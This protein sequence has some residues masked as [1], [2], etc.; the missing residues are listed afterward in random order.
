MYKGQK[1]SGYYSYRKSE[2]VDRD[3]CALSGSNP[4]VTSENAIFFT[5]PITFEDWNCKQGNIKNTLE[6]IDHDHSF[7]HDCDLQSKKEVMR[8]FRNQG[9]TVFNLKK[10]MTFV[11][12]GM[13]VRMKL[14]MIVSISLRFCNQTVEHVIGIVNSQIVDG[15]Y[16]NLCT[17]PF[18]RSNMDWCAGSE[19]TVASESYAIYPNKKISKAVA[20]RLSTPVK[21]SSKIVCL[22][23]LKGL[24][25]F[26]REKNIIENSC[27]QYSQKIKSLLV[28]IKQPKGLIK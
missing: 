26:L 3:G 15:A 7:L 10:N 12:L 16:K 25:D 24:P 6:C 28:E 21:A 27:E 14:P 19:F 4:P 1:S 2:S 23:D 22:Y 18:T 20:E 9:W 17:I 13:F 5:T 8:Q 11:E